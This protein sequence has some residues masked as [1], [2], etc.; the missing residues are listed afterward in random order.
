MASRLVQGLTNVQG[1]ARFQIAPSDIPTL[2]W[3]T[4][5]ARSSGSGLALYDF[6]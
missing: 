6:K 4:T 3:S 2:A 5:N 1:S